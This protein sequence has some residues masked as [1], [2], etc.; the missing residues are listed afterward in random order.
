[1]ALLID[2]DY[3]RGTFKI[4]K[5]IL[6]G[7][8]LPYIA[9]AERR[10]KNWVGDENF[11]D[12]DLIEI[13]KLAEATIVMHLMARNIGTALRNNGIVL[14]ERVEGD[15]TVQYQSPA[16]VEST[17]QG[18][19]QDAEELLGDLIQNN[20]S[21]GFEIVTENCPAEAATRRI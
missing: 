3:V 19:L 9:V 4:H 1:M 10:L 14:Q 12:E 8:I 16:Q 13:L 20:L 11:A 5:D 7:R 15:V 6:D 18:F 2:A 17:M 21:S